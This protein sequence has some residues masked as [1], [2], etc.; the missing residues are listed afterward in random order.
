M[1]RMNPFHGRV[2][3]P[4]AE[5]IPLCRPPADTLQ[6]RYER[7]GPDGAGE[8]I[9]DPASEGLRPFFPSWADPY[10]AVDR[11]ATGNARPAHLTATVGAGTIE[12]RSA[13]YGSSNTHS[14][15]L[16]SGGLASSGTSTA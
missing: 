13:H 2:S 14:M 16:R 3:R 7:G 9:T 12:R 1:R 15:A 5:S 4:S 6:T 8:P 10:A 11:V